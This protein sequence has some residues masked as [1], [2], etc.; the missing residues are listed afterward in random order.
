[1]AWFCIFCGVESL[2]FL[3]PLEMQNCSA[4]R[5]GFLFA[6]LSEKD[7]RE[8]VILVDCAFQIAFIHNR[9]LEMQNCSAVR[10]GFLIATLS[11]KDH[12][13]A[14]CALLRGNPVGCLWFVDRSQFFIPSSLL[15]EVSNFA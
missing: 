9:P 4:V 12:R 11:A 5:C 15:C 13:E 7:H 14:C 8:A 10:C 1:M 6:P 3:K 2:G